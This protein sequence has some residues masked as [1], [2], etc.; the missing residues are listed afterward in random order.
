MVFGEACLLESGELRLGGFELG[1]EDARVVLRRGALRLAV[2]PTAGEGHPVT[3]DK[4]AD[5]V[6]EALL[7][8]ADVLGTVGPSQLPGPNERRDRRRA[9]F[10]AWRT[11]LR[12][13]RRLRQPRARPRRAPRSSRP[14]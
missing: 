11:T 3:L 10:R 7:E 6:A 2:V 14:R 12:P 8:V 4:D 5:A 1:L 9:G 13:F